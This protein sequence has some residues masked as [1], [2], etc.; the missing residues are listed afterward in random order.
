[1][2]LESSNLS[3]SAKVKRIMNYKEYGT[4]N[5]EIIILIH[6]G[7]LSWWNYKEAA[8]I[9]SS[10]YHIILPILDGHASSDAPFTSIE[11]NAKE[12]ISFI[13]NN[14]SG[15]VLL[16]GGLSLG[17]QILLE[18]LSQRKDICKYSL[19][20]SASVHPSKFTNALIGPSFSLSYGLIKNKNFSKLQ[21]KSL[22]IKENLFDDYYRGT[23]LIQ[24]SDMISFMKASTSY[25]LKDEIKNTDSFVYIFYGEKEVRSIKK[26]SK[27]INDKIKNSIITSIP[28]LYHGEFSINHPDIYVDTIQK[29]INE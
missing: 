24:K 28:K 3:V 12:I 27:L 29:I 23:C 14:C 7:G 26:S 20:E 25:S 5:K 17:G 13:D 9:L 10:S 21:F 1:M 6:G 16:I 22:H 4:N 19:I 8:L 2:G 18:M 15:K 11:N